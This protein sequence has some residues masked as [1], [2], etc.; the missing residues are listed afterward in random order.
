MT[1]SVKICAVFPQQGDDHNP[2]AAAAAA[3]D[4]NGSSS[5]SKRK[6]K[7]PGPPRASLPQGYNWSNVTL[8]TALELLALPRTVSEYKTLQV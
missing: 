5:S 6:S 8:E 3:A 1:V 2:A 7:V 4:S